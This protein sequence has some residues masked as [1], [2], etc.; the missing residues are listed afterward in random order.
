MRN[1]MNMQFHNKRATVL[2]LVM[3]ASTLSFAAAFVALASI[4]CMWS[5]LISMIAGDPL[6]IVAYTALALSAASIL[7]GG[8]GALIINSA[9]RNTPAGRSYLTAHLSATCF[10]LMVKG[11]MAFAIALIAKSIFLFDPNQPVQ[12]AI[13][14][15]FGAIAMTF[16]L[17][18]MRTVARLLA[19]H[20]R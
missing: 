13:V 8:V 1:V 7:A 16:Y 14:G 10:V 4:G 3:L 5:F 17:G 15:L 12:F 2:V 9:V 6:P 11:T 18:L 20:V 19:E